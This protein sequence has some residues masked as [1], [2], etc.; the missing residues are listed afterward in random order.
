MWVAWNSPLWEYSHHGERR[1]LW[2]QGVS[3][4]SQILL[5]YH[6]PSASSLHVLA[7]ESIMKCHQYSLVSEIPSNHLGSLS[8]CRH[9]PVSRFKEIL[10]WIASQGH[11]QVVG[12]FIKS[13]RYVLYRAIPGLL[14]AWA[15]LKIPEPDTLCGVGGIGEGHCQ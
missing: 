12:I 2:L 4:Q 3:P 15:V 10:S 13:W 9:W 14:S 8:R 5:G 7:N 1:V 6:C 11:F